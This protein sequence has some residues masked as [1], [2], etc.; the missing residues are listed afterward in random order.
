LLKQSYI[1]LA[2]Q[3][4]NIF[5]GLFITLY[6]AQN[7]DVQTFAIFAIYSIVS[8]LF[9]TFSFLGYET[10]LIRNILHWQNTKQFKKI[11]N[12]ISYA[13]TSRIVVSIVLFIPI[14]VYLYY[15]SFSKFDN[16]HFLLFSSFIVAGFF[17]ALTNANGLI[18]KAF[19]RYILSFSIMTLSSLFGK[20][21]A[22]FVF[23][24][25]GFYGF[26]TTL[27]L[28]PIVSF[29]ISFLYLKEYFSFKHIRIKYFSKYKKYKYF[30]FSGYLN[31]F[32]V[33]FDQFLVSILLTVE[34]L[35]V[36]NLAKKI[37][38]IG[39]SVVEGFFDPMIQRIIGYKGNVNK[40]IDYKKKLYLIKNIFLIVVILFVILFNY[41]V[42][43]IIALASLEHYVN[44]NIYLIIASW[45][46]I[47]YLFYKIQSNII[48]LFDDQKILFKIDLFVGF[49][50]TT[51]ATLFFIFSSEEYIY[52][53]R[54]IVGIILTLFFIYFY[55]NY[56]HKKSIFNEGDLVIPPKNNT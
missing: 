25:I 50:T 42:N 22:I 48:Y 30:T 54:V 4:I 53:N 14:L 28:I 12:L 34:V 21:I 5:V 33:S 44:L 10:V 11:Y 9:M 43:E 46:P 51:I 31:Y 52:L 55:K 29:F 26:I 36:Y 37:E 17:S 38:E 18:L 3:V 49:I 56:F 47:L 13:I 19:N 8:T 41:Y 39:R 45:T 40:S 23:V 1:Y 35:A 16:E 20:L 15:V 7:V 2:L 6:I 27:I 32:K 24:K